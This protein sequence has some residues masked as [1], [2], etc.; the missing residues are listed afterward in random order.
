MFIVFLT[1]ADKSKA[2]EHMAAHKLWIEEGLKAA[3]FLL[4]G[5]LQPARG[6]CILMR[7]ASMDVVEDLV[8]KDP[9]VEHGVVQA[10]IHEVSVNQLSDEMQFLAAE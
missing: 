2:P 10:E 6:G 5:S 9:F 8:A 7:V 1:C 4:V 3:A